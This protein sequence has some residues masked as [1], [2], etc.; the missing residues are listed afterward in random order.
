M[1]CGL[2]CHVD[3]PIEVLLWLIRDA[4]LESRVNWM[5]LQ[6]C[7]LHDSYAWIM[8][9][10]V[11][12][13]CQAQKP[14]PQ[15][16]AVDGSPSQAFSSGTCSGIASPQNVFLVR[17]TMRII[18]CQSSNQHAQSSGTGQA[19]RRTCRPFSSRDYPQGQ[20]CM[21]CSHH[22]ILPHLNW[23]QKSKWT[24]FI[25]D[26]PNLSLYSMWYRFRMRRLPRN[27]RNFVS[28]TFRPLST[29]YHQWTMT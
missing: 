17:Y 12:T 7:M 10:L 18:S 14:L 19:R 6:P 1:L 26:L 27:L 20:I 21:F 23:P 5:K 15:K 11:S 24:N 9:V 25:S 16:Y 13:A 3:S 22:G 29:P 2:Q 28:Y 8:Q 4:G